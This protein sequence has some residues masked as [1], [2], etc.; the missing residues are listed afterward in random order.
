MRRSSSGRRRH[1]RRRRPTRQGLAVALLLAWLAVA[2]AG[3]AACRP[4]SGREPAAGT[5]SAA[6]PPASPLLARVGLAV[7]PHAI[8]FR[9]LRWFDRSRPWPRGGD[10]AGSQGRPITAGLWYPASSP[11]DAPLTL[12]DYIVADDDGPAEAALAK[13]RRRYEQGIGTGFDDAQWTALLALAGAA[14]RDAEPAAGSVP[15]VVIGAG[16]Q[17]RSD[18]F[19]HWAEFLASRGYAVIALATEGAREGEPLQFDVSA[20]DHLARDLGVAI[21][22]AGREPFVAANRVAMIGW[23]VGGVAQAVYRHR[24][25]G[26]VA[27]AVSLDSG[28]AYAYGRDL[29]MAATAIAGP[30]TP[31]LEVVATRP[32]RAVVPR[33]DTFFRSHVSRDALRVEAADLAHADLVF[34]Y[35]VA[36]L[37]AAD[38]AGDTRPAATAAVGDLVARFLAEHVRGEIVAPLREQLLSRP[39]AGLDVLAIGSSPQP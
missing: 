3:A 33:D 30:S 35:G 20:V 15:L 1:A 34:S 23:S 9:P 19:I 7:G 36:P 24:H 13:A 39:P 16:L 18:L 26:A 31:F 12:R 38:P 22:E 17:G 29:L 11:G 21:A 5:A 8:G 10:P 6:V 28:T 14:V 2:A 37:P 32:G 25:P 4:G 27:A